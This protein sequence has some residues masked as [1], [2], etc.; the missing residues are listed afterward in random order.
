MVAPSQ[1]DIKLKAQQKAERKKIEAKINLLNVKEEGEALYSKIVDKKKVVVS[2]AD[3]IKRAAENKKLVRVNNAHIEEKTR[4]QKAKINHPNVQLV[5]SVTVNNTATYSRM[6]FQFT[7]CYSSKDMAKAFF[8]AKRQFQAPEL[9]GILIQNSITNKQHVRMMD[10][11]NVDDEEEFLD[12]IGQFCD[13]DTLRMTGDDLGT[14]SDSY[15]IDNNTTSYLVPAYFSLA[16]KTIDNRGKYKIFGTNDKMIFQTV[17]ITS[18][19]GVS[20][21]YETLNKLGIKYC[22][23]PSDLNTFEGMVR[24]IEQQ[25]LQINIIANSFFIKD[26]I[27]ISNIGV[28]RI[29]LDLDIELIRSRYTKIVKQKVSCVPL[30]MD[31]I[32]PAYMYQCVMKDNPIGTIV[33]DLSGN[34]FDLLVNNQ[35]NIVP[36]TYISNSHAV[37]RDDKIL[38]QV[39]HLANNIKKSVVV[40]MIQKYLFFD[41]ETIIDLNVENFLKPYSLSVFICDEL[42]LKNLSK[43]DSDGDKD[44]VEDIRKSCCTTYMGYNCTSQFL[45]WLHLNSNMINY[46]FVGYNNS[47]FDNIL[48]LQQLLTFEKGPN[49][50]AEFK[51]NDV[52]YNKNKLMNFKINGKH[53]FF[54]LNRHLLGSLASNCESFKVNCCSKKSF[55]HNEAQRMHDDGTL[56]NYIKTNNELREYNEFDNLACAVLLCKYKDVIA[57]IDNMKHLYVTDFYTISSMMYKIFSEH[58]IRKNINL[59]ELPLEYF[60]AI[61]KS[62]VAGRVQMFNGIQEIFEQMV[63]MDVCSLYPFVMSILDVYY[64]CGDKIV[65]VDNYKGGN[66][67]GFYYCDV[68]QSA[69]KRKGLPSILPN[70]TKDENDWECRSDDLKNVFISNVD[71]EQLLSY[72]CECKVKNGIIFVKN[73]GCEARVKSCELFEFLLPLMKEKNQQDTLVGKE[74]YNA[75]L[76]AILKLMLNSLSGKTAEG[77][78]INQIKMLDSVVDLTEIEN[79]YSNVNVVN[80]VGKNIF[81]SYDKDPENAIKNQK[82][83]YISALIYAYARRYMYDKMYSFFKYD[84]LVYTD[85]DALKLRHKHFV[86]WAVHVESNKITIPHW[87]EVEKYDSRYA[88]HLMYSPNYKLFG[89]FENE[90][91]KLTNQKVFYCVQKKGWVCIYEE[92]GILKFKFTFKGINEKSLLL[93][94]NDPFI[95]ANTIKVFKMTKLSEVDNDGIIM[96]DHLLEHTYEFVNSKNNKDKKCMDNKELYY[97]YLDHIDNRLANK[98]ELFFKQL[99]ENGE[100]Y[101]LVTSLNKSI[102]NSKHNVGVMDANKFNIKMNTIQAAC[103]MKR[104]K[105]NKDKK[106]NI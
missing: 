52:F 85:T 106:Y 18:D 78:H 12:R 26:N 61:I 36:G 46:T 10:V 45:E 81:A 16:K 72:G 59:P 54:D 47:N 66:K 29:K 64:P 104:I 37:I 51:V 70:K 95:R 6:Q 34:H 11:G 94:L 79:K 89:G 88:D 67:I 90:L 55:D 60:N 33:C 8:I 1:F 7:N 3:K 17:G 74:G 62:R 20:C 73:A 97:Y 32:D 50:L 19:D 24:Y 83:I 2:A 63:S 42:T 41:F 76:R 5:K 100:A 99:W 48:L 93:D 15:N 44:L 21:G 28:G 30:S 25:R 57:S 65:K 58:L 69:L 105:I 68:N 39:N 91:A 75:A 22:G 101:L 14:G 23:K 27:D 43:A 13:L 80:I 35:F 86:R 82:P 40:K 96:T 102:N 84:E 9:M 4:I 92:A 31:Y 77:L 87:A 71:I 53:K 103:S 98:I 38:L 49:S 56:I